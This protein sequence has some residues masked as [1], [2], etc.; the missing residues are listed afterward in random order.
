M[1]IF[2]DRKLEHAA[3]HRRGLD[4]GTSLRIDY[5]HK[6]RHQ[7]H[8]NLGSGLVTNVG[9]LA[10]A[11]DMNWASPSGAAVNIFKNLK[12]HATGIG[13]AAA[14][15]TD[16]KL[17]TPSGFGGQTPVAG[18]QVFTP[19]ANSQKIVSVAT[20]SYTGSEAVTEWGFLN[21]T[22]LTAVTGSPFT[23]TSATTGTVTATPLTASSA[24]VAGSQQM[25]VE[26]GTTASWG[27]VLTNTTS[28]FTF[29]A[30]YATATGAVGATPAGTETFTIRPVMWDH[31]VFAAI[32]VVNGDSIQFTY[33]LT[34]TSGG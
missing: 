26:A 18:T 28:I 31:K 33:T 13:A 6:G 8:A 14:A 12:Y 22:P 10:L 30:W 24:T 2:A 5:F 16:I 4:F 11:N 29:P 19:A 3:L 23:A 21:A 7:G 25:V 1:N 20:V 15:A 17:Q 9:V 32:N 27:L 34:I